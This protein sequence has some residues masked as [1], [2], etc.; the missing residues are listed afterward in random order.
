MA[1]LL[2]LIERWYLH[3]LHHFEGG[4]GVV[5]LCVV[6]KLMVSSRLGRGGGA[7]VNEEVWGYRKIIGGGYKVPA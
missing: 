3:L 6:V 2:Q 1:V 7:G 4:E 5:V